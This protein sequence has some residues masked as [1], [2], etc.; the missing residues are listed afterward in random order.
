MASPPLPLID[1]IRIILL[2]KAVQVHALK[3]LVMFEHP[4]V[5]LGN[6]GAQEI[7]GESAMILG[8]DDKPNVVQE[9]RNYIFLIVAI[10]ME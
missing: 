8:T 6:M 7:R 3:D 10:L 4:D 1:E 5:L 9:T 2:V